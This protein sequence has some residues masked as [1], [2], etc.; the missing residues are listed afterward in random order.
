MQEGNRRISE[1]LDRAFAT[2]TWRGNFPNAL[3]TH[4]TR[5][6]S[7]HCPLLLDT[8]GD[9]GKR[10]P[11]P[12]RFEDF[13]LQREDC[14]EVIKEAW[15]RETRGVDDV[16]LVAKGNAPEI[17]SFKEVVDKYCRQTGQALNLAKSKIEIGGAVD[18]ASAKSIE[19]S[20]NLKNENSIGRYLGIQINHVKPAQKALEDVCKIMEN[21]LKGWK[22]KT[23]S[24][25]ARVVL[26]KHVL[27]AIPTYWAAVTN[28]RKG[29]LETLAMV[30]Q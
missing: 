20:L 16:L 27:T 18:K 12:F 22:G 3:V 17:E 28:F 2:T 24:M 30:L 6:G 9:P 4:L 7:D 19:K 13:W 1:R 25:A 5:A 10:G 26:V 11:T 21:K 8:N 23:L 15:N 29:Q 14:L